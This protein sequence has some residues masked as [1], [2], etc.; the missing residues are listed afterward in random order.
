MHFAVTK[1]KKYLITMVCDAKSRTVSVVGC[2]DVRWWWT[3]APQSLDRLSINP[4][5]L[6]RHWRQVNF[7]HLLGRGGG[8]QPDR[9]SQC[10]CSWWQPGCFVVVRDGWVRCNEDSIPDGPDSDGVGDG[11]LIDFI[12]FCS[13]DLWFHINGFKFPLPFRES[14]F[15]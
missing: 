7:T 6:Y 2:G 10:I 9:R 13:S 14:L 8:Y 11:S 12:I 5:I 15:P 4:A 1:V 3:Q